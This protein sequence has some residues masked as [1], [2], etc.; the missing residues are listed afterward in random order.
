M[1]KEIKQLRFNFTVVRKWVKY[2]TKVDLIKYLVDPDTT[3]MKAQ[4]RAMRAVNDLQSTTILAMYKRIDELE[5]NENYECRNVL[6][7]DK[8][9][10][11]NKDKQG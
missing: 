5:R 7:D 10:R 1:T 3:K 9:L 8:G 6:S 4:L 2:Y 11:D